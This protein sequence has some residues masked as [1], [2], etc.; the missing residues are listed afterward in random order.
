MKK[1][2]GYSNC[3][4][5]HHTVCSI[6]LDIENCTSSKGTLANTL[7]LRYK[8]PREEIYLS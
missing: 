2:K 4:N 6:E 1:W 7:D 3:S 8:F 5:K